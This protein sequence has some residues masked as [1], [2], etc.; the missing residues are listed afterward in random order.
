MTGERS[1]SLVI[2]K[3]YQLL[4]GMKVVLKALINKHLLAILMVNTFF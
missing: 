3:Y 2:A 4:A 1:V